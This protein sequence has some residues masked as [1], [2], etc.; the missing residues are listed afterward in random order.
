M[1]IIV[2]L[3]NPGDKYKHTRHNVGFQVLDKL[4]ALKLN[5]AV[6]IKPDTFMNESG[7]AVKAGLKKYDYKALAEKNF[8]N[9][10]VIYDDLDIPVGKYKLVFGSVPKIHNGV[11]SIIENLGTDQFWSI[12]I[13]TDGRN[14]DRSVSPEDYVLQGF[15]DDERILIDKVID[16]ITTLLQDKLE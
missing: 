13:G 7:K 9:L 12:R 4:E 6:L 1:N 2:G 10:F 11:N 3:G 14:G 8:S 15:R 16:A 5:D